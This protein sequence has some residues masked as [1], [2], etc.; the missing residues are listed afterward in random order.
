MRTLPTTMIRALAPFAP[1]FSKSVWRHVQVLVAGAIVTPGRRTVGSALR[2]RGLDQEWRFH[3]DLTPLTPYVAES[4]P[5]R[6]A[7]MN[8]DDDSETQPQESEPKRRKVYKAHSM[9]V[10][11]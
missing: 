6:V 1:L 5:T 8:I 9:P 11:F 4:I 3:R 10:L 2:A 7:K